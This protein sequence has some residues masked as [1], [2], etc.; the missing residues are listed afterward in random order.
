MST[1]TFS[2]FCHI[3]QYGDAGYRELPRMVAMSQPCLWAP[4]S[5]ILKS[6]S[7]GLNPRTFLQYLEESKLR[8][9]GRYSW[10]CEPTW[11]NSQRWPG[12][13]WDNEIDG[14]IKKI[15][16]EDTN[17]PKNEKRV[18]AVP[19]EQGYTWAD[20]YLTEHPE[21]I[22]RWHNILRDKHRR[23]AIPGGTR[24]A[25][26]QDIDQPAIATRRI[27]RDAYNHGQAIAYAE[28]D[29]PFLAQRMHRDFLRILAKEPPLSGLSTHTQPSGS[30][31][32]NGR[33]EGLGELA[34]QLLEL[35][36]EFDIHARS[37]G[38]PNSLDRFIH[39]QGREDLMQWMKD[40]CRALRGNKAQELNGKLIEELSYQLN[41][42]E[43]SNVLK[44]ALRRKDEV[45]FG[46]AGIT[47]TIMDVSSDPQVLQEVLQGAVSS[48]VGLL[49]SV[50]AS[51]YPVG[52]GLAR[53]LGFVPSDFNGPQWP[54]LYS[55]G[56]RAKRRQLKEIRYVLD[57]LQ[58]RGAG[59]LSTGLYG[60][61]LIPP[62]GRLCSW[63]LKFCPLRCGRCR[64]AHRPG[65]FYPSLGS[66]R[67]SC[68][69]A[70]ATGSR[71]RTSCCSTVS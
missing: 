10:L 20:Q 42:S 51:A 22:S 46:A 56:T 48:E 52:K 4:S 66:T 7:S 9:F 12:T 37:R 34:R 5:V 64:M 25:A 62:M 67:Q 53:Q 23:R 35:L 13:A 33:D 61:C 31:A 32:G 69:A 40:L 1:D 65:P 71:C 68:G 45:A 2:T 63:A 39:G 6:D 16:E 19:P 55:Y 50:A 26:L 14:R 11:R 28:A 58:D 60:V 24:E 70:E 49:L 59:P 3:S 17:R 54:F 57:E 44:Q 47:G 18:V 27:L 29:A 38:D 43:Y 36:S 21:E 30:S 15:Y 8:I 41:R